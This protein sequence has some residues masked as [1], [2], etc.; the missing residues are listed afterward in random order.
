MGRMYV[1]T[2]ASTSRPTA[3]VPTL[4]VASASRSTVINVVPP[5]SRPDDAY[6]SAAPTTGTTLRPAASK[7]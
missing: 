6:R 1:A 7:A 3:R 4:I 5:S 2:A